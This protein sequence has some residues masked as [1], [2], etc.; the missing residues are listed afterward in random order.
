M[1]PSVFDY[2]DYRAFLR[3]TFTYRKEKERFFSHRY[4]A[5]KA[6]FSSP[7]FLQL[8]MTEKRNLTNKSAAQVA[9]GLSLGKRER[10]YFESLVFMNQA[11]THEERNHYYR[12]MASVR[13][14]SAA[15]K[16]EKTHYEYFSKWHYPALR[17]V[18]TWNGGT[19]SAEEMAA[20]L[21]PPVQ[22]KDVEKALKLLRE[23]R[24]LEQ[25]GEGRWVQSDQA[26]TTEPEVRSLVVAN[27]HREMIRLAAES[28]DRHSADE[29]DITAVTVGVNRN[30]MAEI[31]EK[32]A[33]FRKEILEMACGDEDPAEV[34][35]VNIQAFPLARRRA[36]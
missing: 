27:F 33:A 24:F 8:V 21:D 32:I 14:A 2:L 4:F 13:G 5:G 7:N 26:L 25:D 11:G 16:L 6:G 19:Q 28:I 18:A 1:K 23:L 22:T 29:R 36:E 3:D 9:A 31:R 35:Q 30:R 15:R 12:K 34:I 10:E 17:E 20:L